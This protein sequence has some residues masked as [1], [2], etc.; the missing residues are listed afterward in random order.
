VPKSVQV[1]KLSGPKG[2]TWVS[3]AQY[4]AIPKGISQDKLAVVLDL[5]AFMLK[6]EQQA[7]TYDDG[8]FYPG[9]AVK[10]VPLS[11]APKESQDVIKEFG[12][13]EY[14]EMM[15]KEAVEPPLFG[16]DLN[17]AFRKWDEDIGAAKIKK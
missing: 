10:N 3:D 6:P 16:L 4:M 11:L 7:L 13:P 9:P 8:Y 15:E 12:R 1:T 2:F 17:A 5:I 14:E